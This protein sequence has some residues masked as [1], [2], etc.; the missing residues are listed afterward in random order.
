MEVRIAKKVNHST[1]LKS[2]RDEFDELFDSRGRKHTLYHMHQ[3][4]VINDLKD[5]IKENEL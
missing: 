5:K 1:S 2:L 3:N 4:A